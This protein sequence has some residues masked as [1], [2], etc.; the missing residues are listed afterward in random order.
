MTVMTEPLSTARD[1]IRSKNFSEI[2]AVRRV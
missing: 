1:R 2:S